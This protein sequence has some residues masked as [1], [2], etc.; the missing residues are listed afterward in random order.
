[1]ADSP[2]RIVWTTPAS[3]VAIAGFTAA[4]FSALFP[5]VLPS[6]TDP[7]FDLTVANAASA[8][9]TLGL[10][11]WVDQ[12]WELRDG[13]LDAGAGAGGGGASG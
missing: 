3:A 4:L 9:Y 10:L 8:P 2:D 6:L 12:L 7:A 13:V 1:M 11:S 5:V